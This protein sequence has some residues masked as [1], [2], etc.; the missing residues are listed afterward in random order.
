P[1]PDPCRVPG[2]PITGQQ[3]V[4]VANIPPTANDDVVEIRADALVYTITPGTL[5]ANDTD[6]S[7][8][9]R[10]YIVENYDSSEIIYGG[11]AGDPATG[12]RYYPNDLIYRL[13]RGEEHRDSFRYRV[14][15]GVLGRDWAMVTIVVKGVEP[16]HDEPIMWTPETTI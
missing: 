15:D 10:V 2:P 4:W 12:F 14:H 11:L 8:E 5:L 6:P 9:D 13:P 16:G 1:P 3:T 7:P